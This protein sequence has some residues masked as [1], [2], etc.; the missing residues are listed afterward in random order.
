MLNVLLYFVSLTVFQIIY[1]CEGV[2]YIALSNIFWTQF[3]KE[4]KHYVSIHVTFIHS[5]FYSLEVGSGSS[6]PQHPH[7][8]CFAKCDEL[9]CRVAT[10]T[11]SSGLYHFVFKNVYEN[12]SSVEIKT[13]GICIKRTQQYSPYTIGHAYKP[14]LLIAVN[15]CHIN[16]VYIKCKQAFECSQ[17][18]YKSNM[19]T[20]SSF[21]FYMTTM[22][23]N[24]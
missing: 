13:K 7:S 24:K 17:L 18:T 2:Q 19:T 3:Q 23:G 11:F 20:K 15:S 10:P 21:I 8:V 5:M 4:A 6:L 12:S 16:T 1:Y 9:N 14:D 22:G